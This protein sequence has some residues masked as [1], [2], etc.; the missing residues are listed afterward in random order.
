MTREAA[1]RYRFYPTTEQRKTLAQTFGCARYVYNWALRM[2]SD[3]Y[4]EE[5]KTLLYGDTSSMLTELKKQ[6]DHVWL[7]EVS[8]VPVQQALRHLET[9]YT[10]FFQ[11]RAKF[12]RFKSKR[13][14]QSIEYTTSGYRLKDSGTTGQPHIYL[15]KQSAPL[16]VRWS[17]PLPSV[18]K[19]ITITRDTAGRYFVSIR[20]VM[21]PEALPPKTKAVGLDMGLTHVVITSD[22]WKAHNPK[23]L[24]HDLAR[25]RRAQKALSRKQKGSKNRD[26]ARCRVAKIHARI[27]DRRSDYLHKLTTR[28]VRENGTI[29]VEMLRV[30]NM[31][32]NHC[33]ARSI[34]DVSW[35]ELLRQ[36]EY[37]TDWYGR[38]L[39][40]IDQWYPSSKRCSGCGYVKGKMPLSVRS[41][42]CSECGVQ[43]DRD[44]NA[45]RNILA[46]GLAVLASG[47]DVRPTTPS[48]D[49][50]L[51]MKEESHAL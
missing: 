28:L 42:V 20:V 7:N 51:S 9:S 13:R 41:W 3:A 2:R 23:Y 37:K 29:C 34:A 40:K 35:G 38:N 39:V 44:V 50:P 25:L 45:A 26:R 4:H 47:D 17:R 43:H 19:T 31:M 5:G 49:G 30:K 18:P 24:K 27:S 16:N 15:A 48:G 32:K 46:A 22:G 21:T 8:S 36:L 10:N 1:Y 11:R 6:D 12:P 14:K 33:L